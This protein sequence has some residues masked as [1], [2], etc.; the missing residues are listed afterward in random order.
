MFDGLFFNVWYS[1][2]W[3]HLVGQEVKQS[4]VVINLGN[5]KGCHVDDLIWLEYIL[6]IIQ[7]NVLLFSAYSWDKWLIM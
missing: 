1:V 7:T 6:Q 2:S 4:S 3:L 5:C